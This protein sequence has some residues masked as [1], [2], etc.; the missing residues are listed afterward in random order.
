MFCVTYRVGDDN[1][2]KHCK[3]QY[4]LLLAMLTP[5]FGVKDLDL[6]KGDL[7]G[8]NEKQTCKGHVHMVYSMV[9]IGNQHS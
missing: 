7:V 2:C 8:I 4:I 3:S 6:F 1:T 5:T 9:V